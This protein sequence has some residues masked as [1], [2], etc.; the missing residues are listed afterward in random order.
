[1]LLAETDLLHSLSVAGITR[2]VYVAKQSKGK[3]EPGNPLPDHFL[4]RDCPR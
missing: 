1:M 3:K 2:L 4:C